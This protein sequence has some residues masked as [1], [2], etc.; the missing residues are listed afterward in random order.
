[1]FPSN[2][3]AAV[4]EEEAE[5]EI[6]SSHRDLKP[7]LRYP[8]CL[9]C[10]SAGESL[11]IW[12]LVGG[13]C[14]SRWNNKTGNSHCPFGCKLPGSLPISCWMRFGKSWRNWSCCGVSLLLRLYK[15]KK[16][17]IT[18]SSKKKS[19]HRCR[20]FYK[21]DIFYNKHMNSHYN[22]CFLK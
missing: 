2:F 4:S 17:E 8:K 14:L 1:M 11:S 21:T 10:S 16:I 6:A 3:H 7:I 13:S 12:L 18:H 5:N 9:L 22:L 15:K 20:S 19:I